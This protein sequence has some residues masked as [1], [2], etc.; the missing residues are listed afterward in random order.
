MLSHLALMTWCKRNNWTFKGQKLSANSLKSVLLRSCIN[1]GSLLW[2]VF[3]LRLGTDLIYGVQFLG[4]SL[5]YIKTFFPPPFAT[6][7]IY[8]CYS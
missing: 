3:H 6:F 8:Y 4:G 5:V 7:F 1:Y 2:V